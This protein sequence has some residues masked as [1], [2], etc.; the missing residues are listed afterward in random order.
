ML[1][2]L[3]G[4]NRALTVFRWNLEIECY[5]TPYFSTVNLPT[6]LGWKRQ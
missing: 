1:T 3:F 4:A 6:M 2:D 5:Q